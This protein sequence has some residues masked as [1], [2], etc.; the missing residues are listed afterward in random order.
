MDVLQTDMSLHRP[1]IEL[2]AFIR[3]SVNL[4]DGIEQPD[5]V[6][7]GSFGGG[8]VGDEG[9]YIS[10]VDSSKSGTLSE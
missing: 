2:L 3:L 10:G 8:D 6:R 9:E 4:W 7:A 1:M 5:D